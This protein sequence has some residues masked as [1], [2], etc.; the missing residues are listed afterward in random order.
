MKSHPLHYRKPFQAAIAA[1]LISALGSA[2]AATSLPP[3][4]TQGNVSYLSGG[5]GHDEALAMK[6]MASHYP[7][8]L[9]FIDAT[10]HG[11]QEYLAGVKVVISDLSGKTLLDTISDGPYL[12]AR[13][14]AG[15][16]KVVAINSDKPEQHMV[17]IKPNTEQR[18]IFQWKPTN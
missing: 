12:L 13:L 9:E 17:T 2:Y 14:P 11:H 10:G 5:V 18:V 7:L 6:A 16:Y 3:E 1:L 4:H 15:K 8:A